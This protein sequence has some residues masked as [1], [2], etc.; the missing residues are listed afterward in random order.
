MARTNIIEYITIATAGDAADFGDL[1]LARGQNTATAS[2]TRGL[3][4][5]GDTPTLSNIID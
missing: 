1:T 3:W 5:G 2:P 4:L